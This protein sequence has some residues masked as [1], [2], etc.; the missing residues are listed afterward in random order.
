MG[1]WWTFMSTT[2]TSSPTSMSSPTCTTPRTSQS[3]PSGILDAPET[4]S[5]L[6]D[7][8]VDVQKGIEQYKAKLSSILTLVFVAHVCF[9]VSGDVGTWQKLT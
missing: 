7:R 9:R 1:W 3:P 2:R 5:L 6:S 4:A 8:I